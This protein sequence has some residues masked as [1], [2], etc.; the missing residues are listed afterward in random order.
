MVEKEVAPSLYAAEVVARTSGTFTIASAES[1]A[2]GGILLATG[3]SVQG[4]SGDVS[5][6]TG[7]SAGSAG[8][9]ELCAGL[10]TS[11][12]G[13]VKV[14]S[15]GSSC[16]S[17]GSGEIIVASGQGDLGGHTSIRGSNLELVAGEA[18]GGLGGAVDL[19]AG[20]GRR[21]VK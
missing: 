14:C 7:D 3:T 2:S 16:G 5:I 21:A 18:T 6:A 17:G 1:S 12:G 8:N 9:I 15:T 20:G 13:A 19:H 4:N 10:A 11:G